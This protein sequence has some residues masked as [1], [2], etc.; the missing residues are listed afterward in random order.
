MND[1]TMFS[2]T[3]EEK[4]L[5]LNNALSY[6]KEN[7]KI[8]FHEKYKSMCYIIVWLIRD[9]IDRCNVTNIFFDINNIEFLI[10]EFIEN[11]PEGTKKDW[12]WWPK[13]KQGLFNRIEYINK[14]ITLIENK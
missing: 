1:I 10:P 8:G 7:Q 4:L 6:Y 5:I 2:L 11:K 3:K 9:K 12:Y 13:D 14:I